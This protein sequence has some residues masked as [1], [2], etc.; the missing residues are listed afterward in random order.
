MASITWAGGD[1]KLDKIIE[2][3][4]STGDTRGY[5]LGG[6]ALLGAGVQP[7]EGRRSGDV[8]Q[9]PGDVAFDV[10]NE[11]EFA[12]RHQHPRHLRADQPQ[13]HHRLRAGVVARA[14]GPERR[15]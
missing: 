15:R 13:R 12:L 6:A 5:V 7:D 2:A 4:L 1:R 3:A 11:A 10:A 8:P 14:G 9:R